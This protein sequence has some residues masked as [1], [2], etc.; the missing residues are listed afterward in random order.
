MN[1]HLKDYV[2]LFRTLNLAYKSTN[3]KHFCNFVCS[4]SKVYLK[5]SLILR[6]ILSV[7]LGLIVLV[8]TS[9]FTVF[10]H[11]CYTEKTTEISFIVEDFDCDHK[12]HE[13]TNKLPPCCGMPEHAKTPTCSEGNCCDTEIQFFKLNITLDLQKVE[14]KFSPSLL[15]DFIL[16]EDILDLPSEEKDHIIIS[17]DLPPPLSGKAL[18]IYLQQLKYDC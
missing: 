10:K 16:S 4:Y 7:L 12:E 1:F 9:G 6:N 11:H 8:S 18:H 13:H 14:K 5:M 3:R 2:S 15:A 17:N